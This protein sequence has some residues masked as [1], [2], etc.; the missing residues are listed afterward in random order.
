MKKIAFKV[1]DE[2]D[3]AQNILKDFNNNN[4]KDK[5]NIEELDNYGHKILKQTT[6]EILNLKNDI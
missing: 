3:L 1:N 4:Y 6:Q 2:I 5:K